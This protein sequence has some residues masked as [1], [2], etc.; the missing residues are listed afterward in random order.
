MHSEALDII[1]NVFNIH[2]LHTYVVISGAPLQYSMI[3]S[4][5]SELPCILVLLKAYIQFMHFNMACISIFS[6]GYTLIYILVNN[7]CA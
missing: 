3:I 5:Y 6:T 1:G 7:L 4:I 2:I